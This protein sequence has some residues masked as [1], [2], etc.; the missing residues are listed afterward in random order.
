M[1]PLGTRWLLLT[2][3]ATTG[4]ALTSPPPLA[5]PN[6]DGGL[7][8]SSGVGTPCCAASCGTCGGSGCSSRPGGAD[9]CCGGNIEAR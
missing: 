8:E 9:A 5:D 1:A 3:A 7:L 4:G 2:V 6:C